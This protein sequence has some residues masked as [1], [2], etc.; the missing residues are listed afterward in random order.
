MP[1]PRWPST[2]L[3]APPNSWNLLRT[4][5]HIRLGVLYSHDGAFFASYTR[6]DLTGMLL[7]PP[8][9]PPG[10]VWEQDRLKVTSA[11]FL[12]GR[13]LG[14]LYL[15]KD[16]EDLQE[17][18]RRS[19]Q[20][21]AFIAGLSLLVVYFLTSTLQRSV[22]GPITQLAQIV[23]WIAMEKNYLLR[24]PPLAGKE[25]NQ[26][27]ADFNHMLEEIAQRDAALT[28][29]RDTLEIRVATRTS[30]LE[31][32]VEERRRAE[33]SLL[34]RTGFLNTLLASSPIA[35]M[36]SGLDGCIQLA[37]P[38]FERLFGYSQQEIIG[39]PARDLIANGSLGNDIDNNISEVFEK[40]NAA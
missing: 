5:L 24:A 15:E 37:N 32:E 16:L 13:H 8:V 19:L 11:V 25:L 34:E 38:A 17:R 10:E 35:L 27:G 29:A 40:T 39:K 28:D 23:R 30:E 3:R 36:V 20:L 21:T 31:H 33:A 14:S 4:R 12:D 22:T 2:I 26:L 9:Q 6:A 18:T 7:A 1:P